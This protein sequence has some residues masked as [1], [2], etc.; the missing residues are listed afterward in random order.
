M[1][2][3][4]AL[5]LTG[6]AIVSL[7]GY[8]LADEPSSTQ[9]DSDAVSFRK[10]L[11]EL[12]W[13]RGPKKVS[14]FDNSTLDV[15]AEYLFLDP[16]ETAKLQTLTHNVGGGTNYFLAPQDLH[17][18]VFLSFKDDGYVKDNEKIDAAALLE[19][20]KDGT[21]AANKVRKERGWDEMQVI[22]WQTPPH[23]D[24]QTKRLE[25]AVDGKDLKTNTAIVNFNTRILG[26]GGVTSAVL[27]TAPDSM[28]ASIAD[29]K[30]TLNGFQY[31]PGQ[32][33]AEYKPGD[34][35]AKY[36]LAALVTGGAA[37]IA[38]KTGLWKVVLTAVIA[39]W[40]FVAAGAIAL[41]GGIAKR[42]K[43][44]AG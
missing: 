16:A 18:E 15:P 1:K 23:Y 26:R 34:K 21:E 27:I 4:T 38:V 13:I 39:G 37:A 30:A 29:F 44:K 11:R 20:I 5:V 42:F 32:R 33:Y 36:G 31:S 2:P 3:L 25:W 14:L 24:A 43:R 28:T 10:Q 22:G 40:K 35:I 7:A 8:G 6:C 19:S 9:G 12:H 17:W 41:F